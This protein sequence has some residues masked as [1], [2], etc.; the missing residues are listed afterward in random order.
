MKVRVVAP[1]I[2]AIAALLFSGASTANAGLFSGCGSCGC[3][4]TCGA[5]AVVWGTCCTATPSWCD[6]ADSCASS[7][8][9]KR[10]GLLKKLFSRKN[11][12]SSCCDPCG[13]C[14]E[15]TCGAPADCC[16]AAPSCGC[17]AAPACCDAAPSCG[18]DPCC[19]VDPCCNPCKKRG[20]L[21]HR[22]F[23]RKK[24]CG[25]S[26]CEPACGCEPSCGAPACCN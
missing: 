19:D 23:S 6:C 12:C 4:P 24:S 5:P 8:C 26:C 16:G 3:E 13:D 22:L 14:C 1:A 17:D 21:L 20:G 11:R 10:G 7:C 18:C 15:P 9:K 25:S 2:F